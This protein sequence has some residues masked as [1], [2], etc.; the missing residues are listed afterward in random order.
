MTLDELARAAGCSHVLVWKI[1]RGHARISVE[2][3]EGLASALGV[4]PAYVA[5]GPDGLKPFKQKR[6]ISVSS[7][8]PPLARPSCGGPK[9]RFAGMPGRLRAIRERRGHTMRGLAALA[10]LTAQAVLYCEEG[11]TIARVDTCEALAE[12]LNV[13]PG[14]LAFGET[15]EEGDGAGVGQDGE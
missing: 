6:P 4:S 12:A 11:A 3:A 10:S 14:W 2:I 7:S 1:E 8:A 9:N 13:A 15:P 5:Y